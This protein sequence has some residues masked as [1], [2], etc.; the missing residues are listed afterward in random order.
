MESQN[1][2][3][4]SI[5]ASV[6]AEDD[7]IDTVKCF[8]STHIERAFE[9]GTVDLHRPTNVI[10]TVGHIPSGTDELSKRAQS[11]SIVSIAYC[12][13]TYSAVVV[14]LESMDASC[15]D[16]YKDTLVDHVYQLVNAKDLKHTEIC[17]V[18]N[19]GTGLWADNIKKAIQDA[20]FGNKIT[21]LSPDDKP[22]HRLPHTAMA[23]SIRTLQGHLRRDELRFW[24]KLV[25]HH[26]LPQ[27]L[28]HE[29]LKNLLLEFKRVTRSKN[30]KLSHHFEGKE[31]DDSLIVESIAD[32][33]TSVKL[34]P[35]DRG[36]RFGHATV[37]IPSARIVRM[38]LPRL[39]EADVFKRDLN[40]RFHDLIHEDDKV[41][42]YVGKYSEDVVKVVLDDLTEKGYDVVLDDRKQVT[43][44]L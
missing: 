40:K 25:T 36:E 9:H 22:G 28:I 16:D 34:Y 5:A 42:M 4:L 43:I 33:S 14:G 29:E 41:C 18:V 11:F 39:R 32:A 44:C 26:P 30:G 23:E 35:P 1:E 13:D 21:I 8:N 3:L 27:L 20:T 12:N 15:E 37:T 24:E 7:V 31:R 38:T 17:L 10:V 6:R 19:G 2:T